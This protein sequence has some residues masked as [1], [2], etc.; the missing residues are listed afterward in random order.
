VLKN[1]KEGGYPV[2]FCFHVVATWIAHSWLRHHIVPRDP[3]VIKVLAG[4]P[5]SEKNDTASQNEIEDKNENSELTMSIENL[6]A[7][8]CLFTAL[9]SGINNETRS[10]SV[11]RKSENENIKQ[12]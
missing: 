2:D 6:S 8:E 11:W 4:P 1:V 3:L 5:R 12:H 7:T 9:T 10:L